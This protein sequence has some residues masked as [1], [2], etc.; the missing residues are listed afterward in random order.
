MAELVEV[1]A[2]IVEADDRTVV[3]LSLIENLQRENLNPIEE[4]AGYRELGEDFGL[5]Q[6]EIAQ[7]MGKS[8][9]VITN[10]L[11]LLTLPD[12]LLKL[13]RSGELPPG[14]ARALLA[15][16]DRQDMLSAAKEVVTN[17]LSTREVEKLARRVANKE[18]SDDADIP[19]GSTERKINYMQE[20]EQSLGQA[21]GR[22]VRIV[23]GRHNNGRFELEFYGEDDFERLY[24]NL[25]SLKLAP[26]GDT[27][28]PAPFGGEV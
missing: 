1:P 8:R 20:F 13:V 24:N 14:S 21:L 12:E 2:R 26:I 5:T 18:R 7:R 25:S 6:E 3:E 4:A 23:A 10:A 22:R 17:G 9:P 27:V 15:I 19:T 28:P 11:R 16:H